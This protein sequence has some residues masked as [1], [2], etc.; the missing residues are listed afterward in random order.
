M[1]RVDSYMRSRHASR[2]WVIT[3]SDF[4]PDG[5]D[6][7][8]ITNVIIMNGQDLLQSLELYYPG[9]FCL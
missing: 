8:R 4:T 3:T 2:A 7:A 1:Q 5:R 9:R 6:E